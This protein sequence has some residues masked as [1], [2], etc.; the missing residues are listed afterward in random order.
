M[1]DGVVM[2]VL[3]V[4]FEVLLISDGVLPETALPEACYSPIYPGRIE[5]FIE[6][7]LLPK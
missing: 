6:I 3:Q 4:A 7:Y 1:L 2:D 5:M